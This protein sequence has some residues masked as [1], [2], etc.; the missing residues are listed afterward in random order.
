MKDE[1]RYTASE[2]T[3]CEDPGSL[4]LSFASQIFSLQ[5]QAKDPAEILDSVNITDSGTQ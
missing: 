2:S 5:R 4:C 1:P 3:L